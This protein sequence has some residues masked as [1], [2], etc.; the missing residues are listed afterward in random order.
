MR[1]H[2]NMNQTSLSISTEFLPAAGHE[3]RYI[4]DLVDAMQ[5]EDL[6]ITGRPREYDLRAMMKLVLFAYL[7]GRTTCWLIEREARE[8]IYARWLTQENV[9]SYRTIARFIISDK[10]EQLIQSSFETMRG[11]LVDHDLID[12]CVFIY[13]TKILANANKYSFVWRKNI[14]RFDTLNCE[15]A[16]ALIEEIKTTETNA[17]IQSL[18]LDYDQLDLTVAQL[19]KRVAQ[20]EA[21]IAATPKVSPNPAKQARRHTKSQFH[22]VRR[23]RDKRNEYA[24]DM[25]VFGQR[26]SFSKTDHDATFMRVKEDPMLNGQLKPGYNLQIATNNQFVFDYQLF[27]NPT[28]TRTLIPFVQTL[29]TYGALGRYL[30]ADAGYGS[31]S[32]YRYLADERP[33]QTVLI[34]YGTML[35]E[36]SRKWRTDDRKVMNWDYHAK[37]DYYLDPQGV[38]FNFQRYVTR[39][40]KYSFSRQFHRYLAET[41]TENQQRIVPAF[42]K[43]SRARYIDIN[44]DWE[45]FK[46]QERDQLSD[47]TGASIYAVARLMLNQFLVISRLIYTS[48]D[49]R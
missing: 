46:A 5:Y 38:R 47:D 7:R 49:S 25:E 19:E 27:W 10:A 9:P 40:D 20:L 39:T 15:K 17:L 34:P 26:N 12:D 29:E 2:Y 13:G 31:E 11:F 28:D 23:V 24:A 16:K 41:M 44:P 3:A 48:L 32:N 35:K 37:D 21:E 42:T 43:G 1:N 14:I 22:E 6:Y 8:N 18:P 33:E 45:Y 36:N 4:N 30:I